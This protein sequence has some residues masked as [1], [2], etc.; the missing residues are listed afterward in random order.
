MRSLAGAL[1]NYLHEIAYSHK[2]SRGATS[3][4][5]V[6]KSNRL[7]PRQSKTA[8]KK[9]QSRLK[10]LGVKIVTDFTVRP[11]A[12]D[13]ITI[14]TQK[15]PMK[16]LVWA[17]GSHGN[18]FFAKH[19]HDF[20]L[21]IEGRVIVNG[22]LEVRDDVYVLGDNAAVPFAGH[23]Q[24]AM[25][26]GKFIALHL[27]RKALGRSLKL[28]RPRSV[29]AGIPVGEKWAYVEK[30]G[31]YAAGKTGYLIYRFAELRRLKSLLPHS[32]AMIVWRALNARDDDCDLCNV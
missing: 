16:R 12:K 21:T 5:L 1:G 18:P 22:Y 28:Y 30:Y 14:D 27:E 26:Q 7:L 19:P 2:A 32:Q 10:E 13:F 4:S 11:L 31:V 24:T 8:A 20:A 9:V 23:A 3:I 6:E 17:S 25:N 29:M 15:I